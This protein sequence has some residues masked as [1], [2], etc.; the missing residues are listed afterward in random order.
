M[1]IFYQAIICGFIVEQ[2]KLVMIEFF[3]KIINFV[4]LFELIVDFH[5]NLTN[6]LLWILYEWN[7]LRRIITLSEL[8]NSPFFRQMHINFTLL[9]PDPIIFNV[10]NFIVL[11]IYLPL[12][13]GKISSPQ[14][15]FFG[16]II[17]YIL[18]H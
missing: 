12:N 15:T 14:T 11:F 2:V 7:T 18:V 1:L 8:Q 17:K 16:D 5:S 10:R 4:I 3:Y 6:F 13:P 9:L